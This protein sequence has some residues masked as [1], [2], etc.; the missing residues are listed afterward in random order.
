MRKLL[1]T[2]A[3]VCLL[4]AAG[5]AALF[6]DARQALHAPMQLPRGAEL[7]DIEP[8]TS[9][10]T[11]ANRLA[12][13]GLLRR[14]RY[15]SWWGRYTGEAQRIKAGEYRIEPGMTPLQLLDHVIAGKV[16]QYSLTLVEGWTFSQIRA[17]VSAHPQLAQTLTGLDDDALMA[18]LGYTGRHP[19]GSFLADTYHFPA[20][21]TDAQFLRR[22]RQSM[23][24][25]LRR[26]WDARAEGLP[27]QAPYDALIMA[28][29]IEKETAVPGE[30]AAIAGVFVRRLQRGM[31]LQADPTVIYALGEDYDG[32]IR[33]ADLQHPSAYNTYVHRGLTPTPIAA[34]GP[35]ALHAALHPEPGEALYFV[36]RGDG[37]HHFSVSLQQH[38]GA[39]EKYQL[40]GAKRAP[41]AAHSMEQAR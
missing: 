15:L 21:T 1:L 8:G 29:I 24:D 36:A 4:A 7:L 34:P 11:V 31:M 19:E 35:D 22:A 5:G 3:T 16:V 41:A 33:R 25:L 39:V 30:R 40:Q 13:R 10:R 17:A 26:E 18:R 23:D 14:P 20:G 9:L 2:A 32:N 27:Y 6:L 28:S 12:E 37:T 38:N